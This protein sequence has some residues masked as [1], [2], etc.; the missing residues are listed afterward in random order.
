MSVKIYV[1]AK[2]KLAQKLRN[3]KRGVGAKQYRTWVQK[4]ILKLAQKG[5][6]VKRGWMQRSFSHLGAKKKISGAPHRTT[7]V[8]S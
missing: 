4:N 5:R 1:C 6:N 3:V 2:L 7:F 8:K